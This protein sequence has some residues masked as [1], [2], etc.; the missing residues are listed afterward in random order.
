MTIRH[1]ATDAGV[2]VSAVSKVLR[3]AYGVSD[4]LRDKVLMSIEKLGYRPNTAARGMRGQTFSVGMLLVEMEN[5]F[6]PSVVRGAK[7]ALRAAGYQTLIG[8]GE[9]EMSI[10]QS[11]IDSML[12]LQM[13]GLIL[14]APRLSGALL[15]R[16]ARQRPMAVVGHHEAS[17]SSFDTV[18][19][20]DTSG[21][22]IAVEALLKRGCRTVH[23]LSLHQIN[24]DLEVSTMRETGYL[25][26]MHD[27]G[28]SE[29]AKVWRV[30]ARHKDPQ[31]SLS[32]FFDQPDLPDGLFCWSDLQGLEV[33]N[34]AHR[35]GIPVPDRLAV[36]GYD[37]TPV[38]A[39]P[40]VGLSS[41]EQRGEDLGRVAAKALLSRLAGRTEAEHLLL[42]P[43]LFARRSLR[44]EAD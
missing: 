31:D 12:D 34:E 26:A 19:S 2:S 41:V 17:A 6:L 18:N 35:R 13:D 9:A 23:M 32:A 8:V 28:L 33:L 39:M 10:E 42:E 20:D 1:V 22:R 37:N 24:R 5:P 7:E 3:N 38:A 44:G 25:Q 4:G 11:L 40:L 30:P 36:V 14:V 29:G 43:H 16:Y 21:A 27:A 15:A